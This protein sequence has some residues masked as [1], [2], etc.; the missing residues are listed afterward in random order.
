M[1]IFLDIV[2]L[3]KFSYGTLVRL[4]GSEYREVVGGGLVIDC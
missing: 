3:T 1:H 2:G 4:E